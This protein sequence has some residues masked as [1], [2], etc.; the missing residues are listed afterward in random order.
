MAVD[1]RFLNSA[2][3]FVTKF[4]IGTNVTR[5]QIDKFGTDIT[6]G[7]NGYKAD[8]ALGGGMVYEDEKKRV[9]RLRSDIMK[10]TEDYV[11]KNVPGGDGLYLVQG[12]IEYTLDNAS[13]TAHL[14]KD[15]SAV[16]AH[17]RA[18]QAL[19]DLDDEDLSDTERQ[20][21]DV[22]K[23]TLDSIIDAGAKN[24]VMQSQAYQ[25]TAIKAA[26]YGEADLPKLLP[27]MGEMEVLQRIQKRIG[28]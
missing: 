20:K 5:A 25:V 2:T 16:A 11:I 1:K 17:Q 26:G 27:L 15:A 7:A 19:D 28:R 4:P 8:I 23:T 9:N 24:V 6:T 21:R 10:G 18:R 13:P 3:Q 14:A 12:I 22:R